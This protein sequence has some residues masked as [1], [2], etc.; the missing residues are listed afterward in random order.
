MP[1]FMVHAGKNFFDLTTKEKRNRRPA[2]VPLGGR[3][4]GESASTAVHVDGEKIG[5]RTI[6]I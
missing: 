1:F 4:D 5:M 6:K 2:R 3:G